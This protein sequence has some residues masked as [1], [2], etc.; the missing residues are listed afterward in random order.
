MSIMEYILIYAIKVK[1]AY[2]HLKV[3]MTIINLI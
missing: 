3:Y 1:L 2:G